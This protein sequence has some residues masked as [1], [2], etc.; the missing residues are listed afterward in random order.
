VKRAPANQ[1]AMTF[2]V[3]APAAVEPTKKAPRV[4]DGRAFVPKDHGPIPRKIGDVFTCWVCQRERVADKN[5]H[6]WW[7]QLGNDKTSGFLRL[8]SCSK[9]CDTK[10]S[11]CVNC[12]VY[13]HD[14]NDSGKVCQR[15]HAGPRNRALKLYQCHAHEMVR[16]Y[17]LKVSQ[18]WWASTATDEISKLLIEHAGDFVKVRAAVDAMVGASSSTGDFGR[19]MLLALERAERD[20]PDYGIEYH[21][22]TP[23]EIV[24][25]AKSMVD[26][27]RKRQA[28]PGARVNDGHMSEADALKLIIGDEV[29][30]VATLHRAISAYGAR[31]STPDAER[32]LVPLLTHEDSSV[33][34]VTAWALFHHRT[35]EVRAAMLARA[36][37]E[38]V[39]LLKAY[40]E[41]L[42][43]Q[44]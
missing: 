28:R 41:Q 17:K 27:Y 40:L 44:P 32:V 11:Y 36:Q 5:T 7:I 15:Y 33:R 39:P 22:D 23:E 9:K 29:A 30:K 20:D 16:Q 34:S 19:D 13:G 42:G 37:V 10:H 12:N 43:E 21:R 6:V 3:A 14:R 26:D 38:D 18:G 4:L 31:A 25:R 8:I 2:E 1:A 35:D 24:A